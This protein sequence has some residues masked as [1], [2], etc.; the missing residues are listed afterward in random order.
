MWIA[1]ALIGLLQPVPLGVELHGLV[2]GASSEPL[3]GATIFIST[4]RP[5]RGIGVL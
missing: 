4:A 5:R 2:R 3:E 1:P